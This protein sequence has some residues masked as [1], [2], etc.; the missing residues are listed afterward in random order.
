MRIVSA[1]ISTHPLVHLRQLERHD[2]AAWYSYLS[3]SE[4]IKYT[5]WNISHEKDLVPLLDNIECS[6]KNSNRRLAI[7]LRDSDFLIGTIGLVCVNEIHHNAEVVFDLD[8]NFWNQGILSSICKAVAQWSFTEY[9]FKRVHALVIEG[10]AASEKV[11]S[12]AGFEFE[13]L[14]KNYRIVR[15]R[16]R[17]VL[18]YSCLP[19][20]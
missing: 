13:G 2:I 5:T 1:P 19:K 18:I 3:K 12:N 4:V 15:G 11:L 17:N 9:G 8:P 6:E 10:N 14:L 16:M 7:A 20:N